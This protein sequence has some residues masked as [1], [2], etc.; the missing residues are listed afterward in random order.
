MSH[1]FHSH[2]IDIA[3]NGRVSNWQFWFL[4]QLMATWLEMFQ[5][6]IEMSGKRRFTL[7]IF[8]TFWYQSFFGKRSNQVVRSRTQNFVDIRC[9]EEKLFKG[10]FLFIATDRYYFLATAFAF[11][12][13]LLPFCFSLLHLYLHW[14]IISLNFFSL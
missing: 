8:S 13:F 14:V 10:R 1:V 5:S 6:C 4:W 12:S 2:I 11:N 9:S 3:L 7:N